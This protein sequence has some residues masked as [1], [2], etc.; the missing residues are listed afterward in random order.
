M[1]CQLAACLLMHCWVSV[2]ARALSPCK[3]EPGHYNRSE[4][5][6]WLLPGPCDNTTINIYAL[7]LHLF[8]LFLPFLSVVV[9][10][11]RVDPCCHPRCERDRWLGSVRTVWSQLVLSSERLNWKRGGEVGRVGLVSQPANWWHI[12][13]IV[14]I[15]KNRWNI[16][17][18]NLSAQNCNRQNI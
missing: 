13:I 7:W 15:K 17:H 10:P 4:S 9:E 8:F 14:I 18:C 1:L 5:L 12:F 6:G 11:S 3:A 16:S 2:D